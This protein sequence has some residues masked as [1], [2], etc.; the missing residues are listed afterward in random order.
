MFNTKEIERIL[1]VGYAM[2]GTNF[3]DPL[4]CTSFVLEVYRQA[5]APV[6][7]YEYP[8]LSLNDVYDE[9]FVGHP[10]FL[11]RKRFGIDKR[12]THVGIIAHNHTLIHSSTHFNPFKKR[13]IIVTPFCDIFKVYN[14]AALSLKST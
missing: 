2:C 12:F 10:C 1:E 8:I 6:N 9:A 7:F 3:T 4:N 5:N 13:E 14:Y 11:K